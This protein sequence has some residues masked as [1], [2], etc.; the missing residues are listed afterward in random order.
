[1]LCANQIKH[2]VF[3][4]KPKVGVLSSGGRGPRPAKPCVMKEAVYTAVKIARSR[5]LTWTRVLPAEEAKGPTLA[6]VTSLR[7]YPVRDNLS[8]KFLV[9]LFL[10]RMEDGQ[11]KYAF[12]NAPETMPLAEL[13]GGQK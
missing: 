10:R 8:K 11:I 2:R 9:W 7:V 4:A 12:S 5:K 6:D 13:G 1:M 3:L